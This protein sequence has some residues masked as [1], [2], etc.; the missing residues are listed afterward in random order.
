[1]NHMSQ[2]KISPITKKHNFKET[3]HG[4]TIHDPY[5]WLEGDGKEVKQWA[6][7]QDEFAHAILS[8]LPQRSWFENRFK[9]LLKTGS[10][11]VPHPKNGY[12]FTMNRKPNQDLGV[13][14]VQKGLNGK[15]RA[16]IDQNKLSKGGTTTLRQ[17][18]VSEDATLLAYTL[19]EASNDQSSVHVLDIRTGK[20]LKDYIPSEFYP[21]M[22]SGI[23]WNPDGSGFW[24]SRRNGNAVKGE[25]K[26]NQ[27]VFYHKLGDDY[28]KDEIIFGQR[29]PKDQFPVGWV[30]EDGRYFIVSVNIVTGK[31]RR[32]DLYLKDLRDP[33]GVF[34]AIVQDIEAE[35]EAWMHGD[36]LFF[37]TNHKAP[38]WKVMG[39]PLAIAT[40]GMK[41]WKTIIPEARFPHDYMS[42]IKDRIFLR[43]LENAH[44][45]IRIF[46]L[47]GKFINTIK[48]PLGSTGYIIGEEEGNEAFFSFT[49]FTVP[50]HIYR[51]DLVKKKLELINE[52]KVKGVNFNNFT[53]EQVWYRSKDGTKV[54][55]FLVYKKGIKRTSKNPTLL[56]GYGGFNS[57]MTPSY[58]ATVMAFLERG[59]LYAEPN[60]RGGGEFGEKWHQDGAKA[61]KQNVFDDF[62]AAAEWLIKNDYTDSQHLAAFGWSNGGL[63]TGAMI[64]QRPELF[65]AV[66]VGAPVIDMLRYHKFHGG[67]F[68]I[69]EYG[70]P[71]DLK[72]FKYL[73][74]YSPYH[75][76]KEGAKY[77]ATI[78]VTAEGDDRVHPAHAYKFAA[79]L[80]KANA[81]GNSIIITVEK[82]AGHGGGASVSNFARQRADIYGFIAWQLGMK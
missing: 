14:Y 72:V 52:L 15:K 47:N 31:V 38:N 64:T 36:M 18:S 41:H 7:K 78:I 61:K 11:G 76:I 77:P 37:T 25:E 8:K 27:K 81:S 48:L 51:Y 12:Y 62:I 49:S 4:I 54:P 29:F 50:N 26:L 35:F 2:S 19:S 53:A 79:R 16:L 10:I 32:N 28:R 60:L 73:F 44:S 42:I 70:N 40:K 58:G 21:A 39:V 45:A 75:R 56:Y 46:D 17:W 13:L 22:H 65:K 69:S 55:M 66:A 6:A 67:R 5:R 68:W 82:K 20:K 59:G 23:S 71:D 3:I 57:S 80:Q 63:L 9:E 34:K 30:S 24:Y 74:K 43:Y 33:K 1:M